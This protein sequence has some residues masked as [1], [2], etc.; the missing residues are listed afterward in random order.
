MFIENKY[1]KHATKGDVNNSSAS[2]LNNQASA[3]NITGLSFDNSISKSFIV[4]LTVNIDATIDLE[5]EFTIKAVYTGTD[6]TYTMTSVG[7]DSQVFPSVT[8]AGQVQYT[9]PSYSGFVS[10]TAYF[11]AFTVD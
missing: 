3:V 2:L 9:T 10:A 7:E 11:R 1:N 8:S 5:E 6:W 4:K